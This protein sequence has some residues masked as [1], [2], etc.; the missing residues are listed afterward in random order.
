MV[1]RSRPLLQKYPEWSNHEYANTVGRS[2]GWVKK[3]KKRI[4]AA[5]FEDDRVLKSLSRARLT[6]PPRIAQPVVE[7]I[8]EIRDNPPDNLR[9]IPG[10]VA[11]IYYLQKD[12]TLKESWHHIPTSPTTVWR[13]LDENQRII[14]P[15]LYGHTPLECPDPMEE[16]QVDF[17]DVTMARTDPEEKRAHDIQTF[18]VVDAG[19][20]I[21]IANPAHNE[22]NAETVIEAL[23]DIFQEHGRPQKL[24]FDRDTRFVGAWT[25]RDFPSAF[26]RFLHCIEVEPIVCPPRRPDKNPFV[27]RYHLTYDRECLNVDFP[28]TLAAVNEVNIVFKQHYNYERPHQGSTCKNQPPCIAFPD[29]PLLPRL[30]LQIDPDAWLQHAYDRYYKRTIA[31]S[32]T[33]QLGNQRYYI[34]KDEAGKQ[35]TLTIQPHSRLVEAVHANR[36]LR[37]MPLKGLHQRM[38]PLDE[39]VTLI[40]QEARTEYQLQRARQRRRRKRLNA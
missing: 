26:V 1:S 8:L 40:C 34:S 15:Q 14:R 5:G 12:A 9:R 39:Y 17:K 10:P 31:A 13:I 37:S 7:A 21:L 24:R 33:V 25:G 19:T 38:M 28:A 30:P 36:V 2:E 22:F 29:L 16:W 6:A 11:I 23:V 18:D 20:S 4:L 27:E 32:G 35:V 3:W